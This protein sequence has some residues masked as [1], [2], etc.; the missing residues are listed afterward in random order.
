MENKIYVGGLPFA[1]TDKQLEE[2]F[3]RTAKWHPLK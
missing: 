1:V 3:P 2:F